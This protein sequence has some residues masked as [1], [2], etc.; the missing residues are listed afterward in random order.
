MRVRVSTAILTF[1]CA[2]SPTIRCAK[3]EIFLLHHG[4]KIEGA[5]LNRHEHASTVYRIG[6]RGG[7]IELAKDRVADVI[8][9]LSD[10]FEYEQVAP[11]YADTI[12]AQWALA[13]WCRER[14]LRKAREVH[15]R[16]IL[17]LD[18]DHVPARLG[19]GYMHVGGKWVTREKRLQD[20]GYEFYRGRWRVVQEIE[21][22]ERSSKLQ[23][24]QN[25]WRAK[26]KRMRIG[27]T[28]N[29]ASKSYQQITAIRDP[30]AVLAITDA[31]QSEPNQNVR[32]LYVEVLGAIG[33]EQAIQ[34]LVVLSVDDADAE[35]RMAALEQI[36][37][38]APPGVAIVYIGL[39]RNENNRRVNAAAFA[40]GRL[41]DHTAIGPLIEA[42]VTVHEY[43]VRHG[44]S[45][46]AVSS[47]FAKDNAGGSGSSFMAGGRTE[48]V[49]ETF[50][51][52]DVLTA[53][54]HLTAT[55]G[56]GFDQ[57]AW[58][59]WYAIE[60]SRLQ[61]IDTRRDSNQ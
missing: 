17:E 44:G 60:R 21:L 27:L 25:E 42:L 20:A 7:H 36:E 26:L 14:N 51:N 9:Q 34:S 23:Q 61:T 16:R 40:L 33:A 4:G 46:D 8:V 15:L 52:Q 49:R 28:T 1:L 31:L 13:E 55:T 48:F 10:Q 45:S 32:L 56:F 43:V 22:L 3:A 12:Q 38:L 6:I 57:L 30:H 2:T 41:G 11:T 50:Y 39:L 58:R 37:R 5:L 29:T 47:S 54:G 35:I 59:N 53:L 19:L 24:N 18:S